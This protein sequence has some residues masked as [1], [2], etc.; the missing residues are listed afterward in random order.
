MLLNVN[1][2][3]NQLQAAQLIDDEMIFVEQRLMMKIK[4]N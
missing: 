1:E 4:K 3:Q 2:L